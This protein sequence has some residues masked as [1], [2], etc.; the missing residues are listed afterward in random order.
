[1]RIVQALHWLKP[2]LDNSKESQQVRRKIEALLSNPKQG[3]ALRKD[4]QQ[5]LQ[6]LPVWMQ[7][8]LKDMLSKERAAAIEIHRP[9]PAT[10]R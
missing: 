10:K 9:N 6:T 8:F 4:L 2:K 3:A 5:G 1:M 7:I